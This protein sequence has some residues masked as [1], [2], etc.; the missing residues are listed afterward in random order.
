MVWR[1]FKKLKIVLLIPY[2]PGIPL[3]GIYSEKNSNSQKYMLSNIHND[4]IYNSQDLD[5]T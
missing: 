3:L 2:D 5:I 1:L 4:S